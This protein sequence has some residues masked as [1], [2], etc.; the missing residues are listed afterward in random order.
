MPY[1]AITDTQEKLLNKESPAHKRFS[2]GTYLKGL[3][4]AV[5]SLTGAETLTNKTLTAPAITSPNTIEAKVTHDYAGAAADWTLSAAE[6][7]AKVIVVTNANGACAAIATPTDGRVYIIKNTSG[8]AFT[9]KA[10][11]QT[12][13]TVASTKKAVVMGNGTDFESVSADA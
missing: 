2:L 7:K 12:G 1:T 9:I 11:G 5:V 10:T 4:A 6:M 13:V 8:Q 3:A